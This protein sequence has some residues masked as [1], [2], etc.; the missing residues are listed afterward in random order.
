MNSERS[1][2]FYPTNSGINAFN[3]GEL[4]GL[5]GK[6]MNDLPVLGCACS[7]EGAAS[8]ND[9]SVKAAAR[10]ITS[11]IRKGYLK[12]FGFCEDLPW[13]RVESK[14]VKTKSR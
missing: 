4:K 3:A 12:V 10:A 2:A 7:L 6:I 8:N 5:E 11:L 13:P 1:V 14:T 9:T